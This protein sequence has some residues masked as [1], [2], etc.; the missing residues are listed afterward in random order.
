MGKPLK[1]EKIMD[2]IL[3]TRSIQF[4]VRPNNIILFTKLIEKADIS[5]S[6]MGF[7]NKAVVIE[8]EYFVEIESR[9]EDLAGNNLN[10]GQLYN[11]KPRYIMPY[12]AL[13]Y[14]ILTPQCRIS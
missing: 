4:W 9:L 5:G 8:M 14:L 13:A 6:I 3:T 2:E 10:I 7:H 11:L 1:N 12:L